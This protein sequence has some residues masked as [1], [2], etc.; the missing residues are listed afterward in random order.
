MTNSN[1][2]RQNMARREK[3]D[4]F[5]A[6]H[7]FEIGA[8]GSDSYPVLK[9]DGKAAPYRRPVATLSGKYIRE[10]DLSKTLNIEDFPFIQK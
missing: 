5:L 2:F 6:R 3:L 7:G 1:E 10:I 4:K 8:P 9:K